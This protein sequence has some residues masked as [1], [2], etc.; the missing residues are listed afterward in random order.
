MR[1]KIDKRKYIF[2]ASVCVCV[3]FYFYSFQT[4]IFAKYT[5]R[6]K[7]EKKNEMFAVINH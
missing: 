4:Q 2:C 5:Q 6:K 3:F 1:N 7:I